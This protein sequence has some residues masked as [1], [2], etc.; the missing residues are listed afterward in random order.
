LNLQGDSGD[1]MAKSLLT[2]E[3]DLELYAMFWRFVHLSVHRYGSN[4]TGQMLVVLTIM[5]LDKAGVHPT[6]SDLADIT[7]LPKSSVSRYVSSEINTGFLEEAIDPQDRRRRY[8]KPTAKSQKEKTWHRGQLVSLADEAIEKVSRID[9]DPG[10]GMHLVE[11]LK[12][13]TSE[14]T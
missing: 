8:L 1:F 4:P 6:V 3:N 5:L 7:G 12:R 9:L 11:V 13:L 2:V 10:S 14:S